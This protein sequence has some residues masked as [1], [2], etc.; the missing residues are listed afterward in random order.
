M[1]KDELDA[2]NEFAD[3]KNKKIIRDI[4]VSTPGLFIDDKLN[5][6]E[7][8]LQNTTDNVFN[9]PP[10]VQQQLNETV[11]K[12][13]I[14]QPIIQP[15]PPEIIPNVVP[16]TEDFFTEDDEFDSFKKPESMAINTDQPNDENFD[17]LVMISDDDEA[18]ISK[19]LIK[20]EIK[21]KNKDNLKWKKKI[22]TEK[23]IQKNQ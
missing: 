22:K 17:E 20:T 5:P 11:F 9:L 7:Q 21:I 3:Q 23:T 4:I 14:K 10:Q 1:S 2:A 6:N 8:N 16:K 13:I 12:K 18:K 15:T 19:S